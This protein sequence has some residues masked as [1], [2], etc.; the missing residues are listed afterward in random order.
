[1]QTNETCQ[2]SKAKLG[3]FGKF[4]KQVIVKKNERPNYELSKNS[5]EKEKT[6][7]LKH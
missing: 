6:V 2:R 1:M 5:K 7:T 4:N 3:P